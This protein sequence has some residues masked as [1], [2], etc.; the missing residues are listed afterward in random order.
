MGLVGGADRIPLGSPRIAL[1]G[2][3]GVLVGVLVAGVLVE[4][5]SGD[6]SEAKTTTSSD[7]ADRVEFADR[8]VVLSLLSLQ[9]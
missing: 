6:P 2:I 7:Y 9:R 4:V 1:V 5:F 3:V 8:C